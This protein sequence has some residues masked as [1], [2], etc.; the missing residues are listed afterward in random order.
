MV[1]G[2]YI[3]ETLAEEWITKDGKNQ[4]CFKIMSFCG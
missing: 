4:R 1:K 3:S 2:F